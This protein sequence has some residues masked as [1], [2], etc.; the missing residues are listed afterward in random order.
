MSDKQK[1]PRS[2]AVVVATQL[3]AILRPF[4][5]RIEI[6]GSLRRS[7]EEVGDIELLFIPNVSQVEDGLFGDLKPLDEAAEA[8]EQMV[9]DKLL[10]KRHNSAGHVSAWGPLNKLARHLPSG[11]PVDFFAEPDPLDW[12]R[13]LV[14]R[15]GPAEFNV[16][17]IK[18]AKAIGVSVHAYG[19]GI[20]NQSGE[21]IPCHGEEEFLRICGIDYLRPE[22]R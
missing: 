18:S 13:S 21:R 6:A 9:A 10:I 14:I 2:Q 11:I 8:I 12:W 1:F 3:I 22:N 5:D 19:V 4:V 16:W 15:T 20:T 7:K 17:L